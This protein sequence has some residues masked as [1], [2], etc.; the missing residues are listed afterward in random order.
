MM[1]CLSERPRILVRSLGCRTNQYEGE[2]LAAAFL[3]RGAR[4]VEEAPLDAAIVVSCTVTAEA[5][6]KV[7]QLLRRLRRENPEACLVLCGCL[8]QRLGDA[9]GAKALG[10]DLLVGNRR[11]HL[12]PDLVEEELARRRRGKHVVAA[13]WPRIFVDDLRSDESWDSLFLPAPTAHTRAFVKIQDGCDHFCSYCIVPFVRGKPVSRPE[14]DIVSEVSSVAEAGCRE[15]VL[16][17]VH[18]GRYGASGDVADLF[19]L[20]GLVRRL[21]RITGISRIRFGSLEPFSASEEL[22]RMLADIP[23]FCPHLHIPLQSGDAE[24]LWRMAR[25]YSPENF[26]R[27]VERIR[28]I[29]GEDVHISTDVLVGFPGEDEGA[30]RRTLSF[31]EEM[32]FGRLHV[33]PFSPREGTAAARFPG[34]VPPTVL[35]ERCEETLALGKELLRRTMAKWVGRNVRILVEDDD[36]L[37]ASGL[38]EHFLAASCPSGV[39]PGSEIAIRADLL[40]NDVLE[41]GF[42]S[43]RGE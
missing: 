13:A 30:F 20:G 26:A 33:F 24:V 21:A 23:A 40:H 10:A 18:L 11:K 2:A 38:T 28:R 32:R 35:R 22:L 14:A 31:L 25:G 43:R 29:L 9:A 19:A 16:T 42:P 41:C 6:R 36:G 27:I 5:D 8:A 4:L 34:R 17:G 39:L 12:V 7:K 1:P 15:V 37:R 3:A